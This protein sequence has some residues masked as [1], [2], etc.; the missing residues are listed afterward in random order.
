MSFY[1]PVEI[2]VMPEITY[3]LI[4]HNDDSYRRIYTD[5]R[6]W[7]ADPEPTFA[8]YS[9][10]KWVDEDGDGKYDVLEVETRFLKA[11]AVTILRVCRFTTTTRP[12]SRS[13]SISTRPTAT[14][15]MTRSP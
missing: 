8:G 9:I 4:S 10:G 13:G 15:S 3:I 5:G 2:I 1:D 11:R 12:S 6:D 7:P 14:R